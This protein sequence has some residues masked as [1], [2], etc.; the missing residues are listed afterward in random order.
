MSED[1]GRRV[2]RVELDVDGNGLGSVRVDGLEIGPAVG[3]VYVT[4]RAGELPRVVL[5][6]I[7]D[8]LAL[9]VDGSLELV[10]ADG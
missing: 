10:D 1:P 7:P 2:Y 4:L 5:T 3:G 9:R 8:V 6:V